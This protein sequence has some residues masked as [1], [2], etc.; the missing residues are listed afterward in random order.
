MTEM[1]YFDLGLFTGLEIQYLLD[2]V[3]GLSVNLHVYGFDADPASAKY[4][5]KFYAARDNVEIIN[6]AVARTSGTLKL[7]R[8]K[9][10]KRKDLLG[11][12]S[13]IYADKRNVLRDQSVTVPAMPLSKFIADRGLLA[14][15]SHLN[16]I[17]ANI[18]GAE[19]DM[20]LDLAESGLLSKFDLL[21]GGK[22]WCRDMSKIPSLRPM[23]VEM[24]ALLNKHGV[25]V[26]PVPYVRRN[27]EATT[28]RIRVQVQ[29]AL[30]KKILD[31]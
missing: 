29:E 6:C 11:Q 17:R 25:R 24:R 19:W 23:Q 20:A 15:P 5:R 3:V 14:D 27:P 4:C 1:H 9:K 2:A 10:N 16:V 8:S 30:A 26:V 18:E 12:G 31:G 7:Y 13:S 22:Q 21:W 28:A